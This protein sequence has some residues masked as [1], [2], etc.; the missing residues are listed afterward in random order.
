MQH[1]R[2]LLNA[3]DLAK[4]RR[5]FCAPNPAVGAVLVKDGQ[6]IAKGV[7]WAAGSAHAEIDV[8]SKCQEDVKN[9]IL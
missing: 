1:K 2:F 7:H 6:L 8:L 3:L 9:T 5:G 4:T